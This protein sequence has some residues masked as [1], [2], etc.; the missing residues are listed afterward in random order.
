MLSGYK[1]IMFRDFLR[2]RRQQPDLCM[3][4]PRG[5]EVQKVEIGMMQS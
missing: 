2:L 1:Y 5:V 4:L 3:E